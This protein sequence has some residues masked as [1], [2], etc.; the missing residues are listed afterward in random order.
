VGISKWNAGIIRP[1]AVA[2]TGP[3]EN[4]AAPGVWTLDQQAYWQKQGLWP[5]AG[6]TQNFIEDMFSTW[7]YTGTGAAQTITNGIDLAGKGGLVW[8]KNR[9]DGGS[10]HRLEDTVRGAGKTLYSND[11]LAE[12]SANPN[13][14]SFNANGFSVTTG[15]SSLSGQSWASWTF[16]EQPKFFDIV[17]Y[18][19]DGA[20]SRNI[21]HSLGSTPGMVIIKTT[22]ATSEWIVWHRSLGTNRYL[23]LNSAFGC[24]YL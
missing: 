1:V 3:F 13:L 14:T 17:T 20:S 5:I 15:A 7:L 16:R 2:P 12:S 23:L 18:T 24:K 8:L 19:G 11:T 4:G 21:A 9:T 10:F 6:N 22:S